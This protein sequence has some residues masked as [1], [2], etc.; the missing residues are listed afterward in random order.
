[1][2]TLWNGLLLLAG[3]GVAAA[4]DAL[5]EQAL[6]RG[7]VPAA[8]LNGMVRTTTT[9]TGGD[10]PELESESVDPRKD[11]KK[12][13]ASYAELRD[14][15]GADAR[16]V[17]QAAG[18]A[19]YRFTTRHLPRGTVQA[20]NVNVSSDGKG[21]DEL[22]D[23]V[24]TV[25]KDAAGKPF[26]DHLDLKLHGPAGNI[27]GR[28]KK[29]DVS[30]AFAPTPGGEAML[31]TACT[32]DAKVRLFFFVHREAHAESQWIAAAPTP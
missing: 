15:V 26:V 10:K 3:T 13:M 6:A 22:F 27:I 2:R 28:V 23:G 29:V 14:V 20:G 7:A 24:L 32:V 30:Y 5:L 31:T 16:M 12:A 11:P 8:G 25:T 17:G 4:H 21:D 19:T 18:R 1:M 9:V